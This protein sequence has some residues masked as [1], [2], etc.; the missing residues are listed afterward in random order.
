MDVIKAILA[1]I[2]FVILLAWCVL[3]SKQLKTD[4]RN[5]D[6]AAC[7]EYIVRGRFY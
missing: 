4:C 6:N 2:A 7:A 5:G 1:F 3:D